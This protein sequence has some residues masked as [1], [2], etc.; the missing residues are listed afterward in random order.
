MRRIAT[1]NIGKFPAW[2]LAVIFYGPFVAGLSTIAAAET[3]SAKHTTRTPVSELKWKKLPNGRQLSAVYGDRTKG[4]HI[5]FVKFAP[6]MK[7]APHTHSNDYIGI[8]VKGTARHYEP[9]K[10]ETETTL[11]AGSHWAVPAT[12]VHI[13]E[14]LPGSECIFAIRQFRAFDIK[15]AH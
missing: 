9:G 6:G 7:T 1:L 14:C 4:P 13:S 5:T 11:P 3:V 10:P 15:P 8:V 2:G 12:V